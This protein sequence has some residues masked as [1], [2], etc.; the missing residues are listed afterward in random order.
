MNTLNNI[1]KKNFS[2]LCFGVYLL[3][4]FLFSVSYTHAS[5]EISSQIYSNS[6]VSGT[7]NATVE[8]SHISNSNGETTSYY[9]SSSSPNNIE[10]VVKIENGTDIANSGDKNAAHISDQDFIQSQLNTA[11]ATHTPSDIEMSVENIQL[12]WEAV[13]YLYWYVK[14]IF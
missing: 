5:T 3:V 7:G 6:S 2:T 11:S 14:N 12:L 13:N 1:S 8:I 10:H 4:L 9:Y